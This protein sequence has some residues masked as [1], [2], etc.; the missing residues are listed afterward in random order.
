[1]R[2]AVLPQRLEELAAKSVRTGKESGLGPEIEAETAT[3]LRQAAESASRAMRA[4][5]QKPI[6]VVQ[7]AIRRAVARVVAGLIPVI[8]LEEIPETLPMQVVQTA[9][10]GGAHG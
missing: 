8:A 3:H 9:E 2:V 7:G 10:P 6:L 5:G 1:L 4:R